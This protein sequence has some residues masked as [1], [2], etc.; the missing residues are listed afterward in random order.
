MNNIVIIGFQSAG[1]TAA[2]AAHI[3]D[4]RAEVTVVERRSYATYHP[5]GL[6]YAI[7]GDVSDIH[8]LVEDEPKMLGVDVRLG[9]EAKYIDT[10]AKNVS[11]QDLKTKSEEKISY[12]SLILATGGLALKPSIPGVDL[13][14][15]FT[16]RTVE[17]GKDIIASLA[18]SKRAVVVG[19]GPIGVEVASALKKKGLETT[20]V[21]LLPNI[22]PG[23]LDS[24]MAATVSE[25]L[26][27]AEIAVKYGQPVQEIRGKDKVKSVILKDEEISTDLVILSVGVRPDV[28]L[29]KKIGLEVG[30]TGMIA[31]DDHLRTS[32]ADVYAA[33]D[34]AETRCFIT[35]NP[36]RSQLATTA[37]RMGKVAGKNV[38]G[39][40]EIF[41]GVLN[42]VVCSAFGLEVAATGLTSR[43]AKDVGI[44]VAAG[45]FRTLSKPRYFPG[46]ELLVVKLVADK[47]NNKIIGGQIIGDG[48]TERTNVLA[49][50]IT[51]GV[52]VHEM[53]QMEYSY[54]PPF[55]DCIEPVVVAADA[56]LRR[57]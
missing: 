49:L 54:A 46:A 19:A 25:H 1:L 31:V 42:T 13:K 3:H 20:I 37:I 28:E 4:R 18:K 26:N 12:D 14:N 36:I 38:V 33:G 9:K 29:A 53:S 50:A 17:D 2:A 43:I 23:M 21:E 15:V 45:R 22:L 48:A 52:T 32:A 47:S 34:C 41:P 51:K 39:G 55:N 6:P 27:K 5:C 8:E 11:I 16:L 7:S 56:L 30:S 35:K 24:D 57:M 44:D 10:K 40:D